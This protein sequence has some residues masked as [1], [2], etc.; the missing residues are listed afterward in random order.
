MCGLVLLI[1]GYFGGGA[2][3]PFSF[4]PVGGTDGF[5]LDSEGEDLALWGVLALQFFWPSGGLDSFVFGAAEE[6]AEEVD[7]LLD[8]DREDSDFLSL[9]GF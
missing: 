3:F 4:P 5:G 7:G 8:N 1:L 6:A 9:W 2:T